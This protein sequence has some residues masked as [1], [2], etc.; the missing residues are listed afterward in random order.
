[1][2][3]FSEGLLRKELANMILKYTLLKGAALEVYW[4]E[5]TYHLLRAQRRLDA[6]LNDL[7]DKWGG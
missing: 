4:S 2:S 7:Q 1:M 6:C 5:D 3:K